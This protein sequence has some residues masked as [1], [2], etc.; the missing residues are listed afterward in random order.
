MISGCAEGAP[1][2]A[3]GVRTA[4]EVASGGESREVGANPRNRLHTPLDILTRS[5]HLTKRRIAIQNEHANGGNSG[6]RL[7][8]ERSVVVRLC[9][10]GS[11][12]LARL[13]MQSGVG[14]AALRPNRQ[15]TQF[16]VK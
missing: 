13:C 6:A 2:A 10:H 12:S 9:G 11:V 4:P 16:R 8:T 15:P 14:F 1:P 3:A 5:Y 7:H